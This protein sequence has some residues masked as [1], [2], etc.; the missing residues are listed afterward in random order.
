MKLPGLQLLAQPIHDIA[1]SLML[2]LL[3]G[4]SRSGLNSILYPSPTQSGQAPNGLLKEKLLG[5][6]SGMLIPQSGQAKLS[7]K[8]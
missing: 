1:P 4:I 2:K 3:S 7:E 8:V 5:S 6:I